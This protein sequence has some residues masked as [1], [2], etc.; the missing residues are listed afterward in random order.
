VKHLISWGLGLLFAFAL[1]IVVGTAVSTPET[2]SAQESCD[3]S[4]PSICVRPSEGDYDCAGSGDG[5]N[6]V[7][8]PIEVLPPDPHG[9]DPDGDGTGCE[10]D[11]VSAPD[12]QGNQTDPTA[13]PVPQGSSNTPQPT[14]APT[15]STS[16]QAT[17]T[18]DV[19]AISVAGFGPDDVSSGGPYA[20]L[21]AGL[22]GAGIAWVLSAVAAARF[23]TARPGGYQDVPSQP[24]SRSETP[25]F[26][27]KV[28]PVRW[29]NEPERTRPKRGRSAPPPLVSPP[30][31]WRRDR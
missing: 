28:R 8:G 25:G 3:P 22:A 23:A 4:Y 19:E 29:N 30:P 17:P 31:F 27:V 24:E 16:N 21:I 9:L 15:G 1:A 5:P 14:L 10:E 7:V 12:G 26:F 6:Y 11:E 20:W 2:V 13:T 18:S